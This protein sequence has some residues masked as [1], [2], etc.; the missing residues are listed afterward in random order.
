MYIILEGTARLRM[1]DGTEKVLGQSKV[2]GEIE[3]I[4]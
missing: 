1:Q 4:F 2:L 3:V